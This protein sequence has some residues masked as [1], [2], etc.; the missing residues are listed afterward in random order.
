MCSVCYSVLSCLW[1]VV[2]HPLT[3]CSVLH[4]LGCAMFI[5]QCGAGS[6]SVKQ[7]V[8]VCC[9]KVA[10]CCSLLQ[11]VAV[12]CPAYQIY[13]S[14]PAY[15]MLQCIARARV[16]DLCTCV[17]ISQTCM[18]IY[19]CMCM[20]IHICIYIYMRHV[21]I[22]EACANSGERFI[23]KKNTEYPVTNGQ[24]LN[25]TYTDAGEASFICVAWLL[26]MCDMTHSYEWHDSFTWVMWR[27]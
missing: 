18:Y 8:A 11:H 4:E 6:W 15:M 26:H 12:R 16:H 5:L 3:F 2:R 20:Y 23:G 1:F 10:M 7:C 14:S 19:I 13:G 25:W 24:N 22:V 17:F 21:L 27:I 9:S